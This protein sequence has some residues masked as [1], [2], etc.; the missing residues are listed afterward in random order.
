ME[1]GREAEIS[2]S[3][4]IELAHR[5]DYNEIIQGCWWFYGEAQLLLLSTPIIH[6]ILLPL[7]TPSVPFLPKGFIPRILLNSILACDS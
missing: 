1:A 2:V 4:S 6:I 7:C 3:L 5:D